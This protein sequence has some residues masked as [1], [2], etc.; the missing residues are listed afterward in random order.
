MSTAVRAYIPELPRRAWT[1]LAAD[2][3]SALGSGLVL[4]FFIIYLNQVRGI[5]VPLAALALSTIAVVGLV[6]SPVSGT[7]VDRF[8][9]R[10]TLASMVTVAALGAVWIAFVT[11]P[12]EAFAAAAV[13]GTGVAG[14]WPAMN[15][16][17]NSTVTPAQRSAA[18]SVHYTTLNLGLGVGGVLSG[19]FVDVHSPGTFQAVYL[20]DGLSFLVFAALVSR[21]KGIGSKVPAEAGT[22]AARGYLTVFRDRTFLRVWLLMTMIVMVGYAQLGSAWPAFASGTGGVSTRV[23]GLAFGVNTAFIVLTQFVVLKRLAGHRRTRAVVV[24]SALWAACW[25]VTLVAGHLGGGVLAIGGF[26]VSMVLFAAG[27]TLQSPSLAPMVNDLAADDLRG[28]YNAAYSLSWSVGDMI[29]PA[30]A[31]AALGAGLSTPLFLGLIA[32]CGVTAVMALRLERHLPPGANIVTPNEGL[33]GSR[34][35][36]RKEASA[37][38][39]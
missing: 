20:V 1:L 7:L 39:A 36:S 10:V 4:P 26:L 25:A 5:S 21:M 31:G 27:E 30:I 34:P 9:A 14:F 23:I 13:F 2:A 12:W 24:L 32:A 29:G 11:A 3:L 38:H 18:F 15:S 16:T 22:I 35:A 8:G 6:A 37:A 17:L 33:G 19:L 28:R